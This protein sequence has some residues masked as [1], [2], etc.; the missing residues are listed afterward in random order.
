[1]LPELPLL[2]SLGCCA[3]LR[4]AAEAALPT[5][6]ID[7][8][9]RIVRFVWT[10]ATFVG[11]CGR[12]RSAAAAAADDNALF[13]FWLLDAMKAAAAAVEAL[14]FA[15]ALVSCCIEEGKKS[16]LASRTRGT[17]CSGKFIQE[18]ADLNIAG[19]D[20]IVR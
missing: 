4:A 17:G 19:H 16:R 14:G 11:V 7:G 13:G 9:R 12:A 15:V 6:D 8:L 20:I 2:S 5:D 3:L 1:M 10:S 18:C